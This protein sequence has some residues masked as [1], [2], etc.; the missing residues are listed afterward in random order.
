[1]TDYWI[2]YDLMAGVNIGEHKGLC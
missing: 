1:M 2:K